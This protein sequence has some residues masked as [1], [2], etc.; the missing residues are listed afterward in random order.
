MIFAFRHQARR[1]RSTR[2]WCD[3]LAI[4]ALL[5]AVRPSPWSVH[6]DAA[7][8]PLSVELCKDACLLSVWNQ[9]P[10]LFYRAARHV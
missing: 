8:G 1:M 10:R 3:E 2:S 4:S 9:V 7:R 6:S 5:A